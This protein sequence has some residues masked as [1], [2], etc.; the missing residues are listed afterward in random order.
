MSSSTRPQKLVFFDLESRRS[1]SLQVRM[2]VS[3]ARLLVERISLASAPPR[4]SICGKS[5]SDSEMTCESKRSS[6][7]AN[8]VFRSATLAVASSID[9][10]ISATTSA[11]AAPAL[12]LRSRKMR[13]ASSSVPRSSASS[14]SAL[15]AAP[16]AP[17]ALPLVA[18]SPLLAPAP[19][20]AATTLSTKAAPASPSAR[21]PSSRT[22][23]MRDCAAA[24]LSVDMSFS[25]TR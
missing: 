14:V 24:K 3:L 13:I 18:A 6:I 25:L 15:A 16:F 23:A 21:T 12:D 4:C 19:L 5:A 7:N 2:K 17:S 22:E 9:R 11:P 20:T 8:G 1:S 10:S